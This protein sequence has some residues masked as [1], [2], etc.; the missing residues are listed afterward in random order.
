VPFDADGLTAVTAQYTD[1]GSE[2]KLVEFRT[3]FASLLEV[4]PGSPLH[5]PGDSGAWW[6]KDA[7]HLLAELLLFTDLE[8]CQTEVLGAVLWACVIYGRDASSVAAL[9]VAGRVHPAFQWGRADQPE[10]TEWL[11]GAIVKAVLRSEEYLGS[12]HVGELSLPQLLEGL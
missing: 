7:F 11:C 1:L 12:E 5:V 8:S 10:E 9:L 4:L 2:D 3:G 6:E